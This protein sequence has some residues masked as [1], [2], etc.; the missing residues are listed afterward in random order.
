MSQMDGFRTIGEIIRDQT[1][2]HEN[3]ALECLAAL[4][5]LPGEDL[6]RP[7]FRAAAQTF[8]LLALVDR[9]GYSGTGANLVTSVRQ[10]GGLAW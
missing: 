10:A 6:A 5:K 8:A 1:N 3:R 2:S 9:I 7:D 4:D